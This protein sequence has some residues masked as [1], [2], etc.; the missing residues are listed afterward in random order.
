MQYAEEEKAWIG[1]KK[2]LQGNRE[3]LY[4]HFYGCT[5]KM[6]LCCDEKLKKLQNAV[7]G[8]CVWNR[9]RI[10]IFAAPAGGTMWTL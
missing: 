9:A 8:H 1:Y 4:F 7:L 6:K 5:E 3:I 10:L 2:C